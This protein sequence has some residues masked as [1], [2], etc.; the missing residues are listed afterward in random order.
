MKPHKLTPIQESTIKHWTKDIPNEGQKMLFHFHYDGCQV[1]RLFR[2]RKELVQVAAVCVSM[3]RSLEHPE[4][5]L[6][7]AIEV[8]NARLM[9]DDD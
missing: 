3:I 9:G 5:E 2:Y 1:E 4:G 8:R 6:N 7:T